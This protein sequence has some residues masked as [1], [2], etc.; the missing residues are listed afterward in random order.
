MLGQI[1]APAGVRRLCVIPENGD[2]VI[3]V[4]ARDGQ[5]AFVIRRNSD[6]SDIQFPGYQTYPSVLR[7]IAELAGCRIFYP[8]TD[9]T[10]QSC[11]DFISLTGGGGGAR[12]LNFGK[13]GMLYDIFSD[14][15]IETEGGSVT[16]EF[17]PYEVKI[18]LTGTPEKIQN[19]R[20]SYL[21]KLKSLEMEME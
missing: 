11:R 2:E 16:L 15:I 9:S 21:A 8:Y 7:A 5:A 18:L 1:A 17:M 3:A 10:I 19:F 4:S 12:T 20:K 14:R 6:W 13:N